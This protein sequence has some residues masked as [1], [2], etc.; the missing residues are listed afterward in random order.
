MPQGL[1]SVGLMNQQQPIR[2]SFVRENLDTSGH[3]GYNVQQP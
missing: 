3:V 1:V 2:E